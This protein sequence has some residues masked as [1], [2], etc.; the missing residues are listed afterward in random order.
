MSTKLFS[1]FTSN[2]TASLSKFL[3]KDF[4]G[5]INQELL[6]N[7]NEVSDVEELDVSDE[8][9]T[10]HNVNSKKLFEV[11]LGRV[12]KNITRLKSKNKKFKVQIQYNFEQYKEYLPHI[13][14][15]SKSVSDGTITTN[16]FTKRVNTKRDAITVRNKIRKTLPGRITTHDNGVRKIENTGKRSIKNSRSTVSKDLPIGVMF[17]NASVVRGKYY[18]RY[19]AVYKTPEGKM[20]NKTFGYY[21]YSPL[22]INDPILDRAK[23][24]AIAVRNEYEYHLVKSIPYYVNYDKLKGWK[25]MSELEFRQLIDIRMKKLV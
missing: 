21:T 3:N 20:N 1:G 11:K 22:G 18:S 13:K 19:T 12:D 14:I 9:K 16:T 2:I 15:V 4:S 8:I 24:L 25:K 5:H 23:E 10:P 7:L 6:D 17:N